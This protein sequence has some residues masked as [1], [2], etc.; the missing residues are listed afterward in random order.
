[1]CGLDEAVQQVVLDA[2][3]G[4]GVG[5]GLDVAALVVAVGLADGARLCELVDDLGLSLGLGLG[6]C[7]CVCLDVVA[8]IRVGG[9]LRLWEWLRVGRVM[10]VGVTVVGRRERE[11]G[12]RGGIVVDEVGDG[13]A[14]ALR[15]AGRGAGAALVGGGRGHGAGHGGWC[16]GERRRGERQGT[17]IFCF[18]IFSKK[19]KLIGGAK[20]S[21]EKT[22]QAGGSATRAVL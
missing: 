15:G 16:G 11:G 8:L 14:A 20:A 22:A 9:R 17:E 7:L 10:V 6:V 4:D 19:K 2:A 5:Q 21:G 13:E 1:M 12:G 3:L 18:S